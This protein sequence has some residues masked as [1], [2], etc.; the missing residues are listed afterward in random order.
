MRHFANRPPRVTHTRS[1]LVESVDGWCYAGPS[2]LLYLTKY[3]VIRKIDWLSGKLY[4]RVV[5]I[6]K[7]LQAFQ[8]ALW[9]RDNLSD[10]QQTQANESSRMSHD[11]LT[12]KLPSSGLVS[13]KRLASMFDTSRR[14]TRFPTEDNSTPNINSNDRG[15]VTYHSS[16][17]CY[18]INLLKGPNGRTPQT[19]RKPHSSMI[20]LSTH[21]STAD[22]FRK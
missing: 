9:N 20:Q 18:S 16:S 6:V 7:V 1:R 13:E 15:H 12:F 3:H 22:S 11:D 10:S 8:L 21:F 14:S 2:T 17:K 5:A 4:T 19:L